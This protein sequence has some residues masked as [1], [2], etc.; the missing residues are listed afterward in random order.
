VDREKTLGSVD[1]ALGGARKVSFSSATPPLVNI[2]SVSSPRRE[3]KKEV[4]G[5]QSCLKHCIENIARIAKRCP[6]NI[7]RLSMCQVIFHLRCHYYYGHYLYCCSVATICRGSDLAKMR[8]LC[9]YTFALN[10]GNMRVRNMKNA[11]VSMQ[12]CGFYAG[13]P[14]IPLHFT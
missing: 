9:G 8:V 5:F 2:S 3:C 1:R 11:G 4:K 13:M 10:A 7:A 6:S 14:N 12:K